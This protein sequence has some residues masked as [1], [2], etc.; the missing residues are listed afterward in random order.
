MSLRVPQMEVRAAALLGG[1]EQGRGQKLAAAPDSGV[2]G[3][4][5]VVRRERPLCAE[6]RSGRS[7]SL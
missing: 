7:A 1:G 4:R 2:I 3:A 6:A 5:A